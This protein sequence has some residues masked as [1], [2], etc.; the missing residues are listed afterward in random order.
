MSEHANT[1]NLGRQA[2]TLVTKYLS[3]GASLPEAS[4][5]LVELMNAGMENSGFLSAEIIPPC[6][7]E[8]NEWVLLQRFRTSDFADSWRASGKRREILERIKSSFKSDADVLLEEDLE[9]GVRG[10]VATAIITHVRKGK[11]QEYRAWEGKMQVKQAQYP[12]YRGSYV[13]PPTGDTDE[14]WTTMLRFDSP[15]TL[16]NW[17]NSQERAALLAEGQEI[18]ASTDFRKVSMSF[19]GWFPLDE[20]TGEAPAAWKT[21]M[22]VILGLFPIVMLEIKYLNPILNPLPS[23]SLSNFIGNIIS[24]GLTSYVTVPASINAFKWWI[25]PDSSA[26]RAA[27]NMKGTLILC[28]LFAIEIGLMW[29]LL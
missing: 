26:N 7:P 23:A 16:N 6:P 4:S 29:R 22:L 25:F 28:L 19:P 10:S 2:K 18:V 5:F 14:Q 27:I 8:Q 15:E 3:E 20:K 9:D 24:V 12:G 13:Q 17:F 11:E 21:S 1:Q